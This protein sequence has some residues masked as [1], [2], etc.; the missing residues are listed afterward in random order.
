M[1]SEKM[2]RGKY[3]SAINPGGSMTGPCDRCRMLDGKVFKLSQLVPTG[4]Y[5]GAS[6]GMGHHPNCVCLFTEIDDD[7]SKDIGKKTAG[8]E[9]SASRAASLVSGGSG[10]GTALGLAALAAS[11]YLGSGK[12]K[13]K[14]L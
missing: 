3:R 4:K 7:S 14:G 8:K 6:M 10:A 11:A 13:K 12:K 2:F 5:N 1:A 9:L